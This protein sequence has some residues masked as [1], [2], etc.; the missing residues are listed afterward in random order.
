MNPVTFAPST[1]VVRRMPNRMSGSGARS[2]HPTNPTSRAAAR[3]N[4]PIV[5]PELQ[6][7]LLPW[8][9]PST[10][11]VRPPVTRN[12]PSASKLLTRGSR[13]SVSSTGANAS[14]ARATGMLT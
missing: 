14:A 8:V 6:P 3:T 9:M 13:L 10:S 2:S 7:Q 4:T 5:R 1:V 12:A 11:V